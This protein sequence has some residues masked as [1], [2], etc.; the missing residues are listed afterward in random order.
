M[1]T[2][3]Q[4]NVPVLVVLPSTERFTT[5]SLGVFLYSPTRPSGCY[6]P[7][8]TNASS[9]AILSFDVPV[10]LPTIPVLLT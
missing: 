9:A 5:L 4:R 1:D 3:R 7:W 2:V 10:L 8:P 6:V